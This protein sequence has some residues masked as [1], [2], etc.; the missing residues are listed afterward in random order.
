MDL[1]GYA[2]LIE[3]VL[4]ISFVLGWGILELL[5]LWM[6]K[7]RVAEKAQ[8]EAAPCPDARSRPS[9]ESAGHSER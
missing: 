9:A 6:D 5:G 1:S 4:V 2:G 8:R 7:K 3:F